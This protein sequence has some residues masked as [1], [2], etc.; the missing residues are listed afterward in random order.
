MILTVVSITWSALSSVT[1]WDAVP[2]KVSCCADFTVS[3]IPL[4]EATATTNDG[5]TQDSSSM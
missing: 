4:L 5:K 3:F 2:A 1:G